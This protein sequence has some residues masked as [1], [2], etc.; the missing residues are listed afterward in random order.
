MYGFRIAHSLN[1]MSTFPR[2]R[3]DVIP[4]VQDLFLRLFLH[5]HGAGPRPPFPR[6]RTP[7][8]P[9]MEESFLQS[10]SHLQQ[11]SQV[12]PKM[13]ESFLQGDSNLQQRQAN[14]GIELSKINDVVSLERCKNNSALERLENRLKELGSEQDEKVLRCQKSLQ[15]Q[16]EYV[17]RLVLARGAGSGAV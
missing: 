1:E 10:D 4:T 9:K 14:L 3:T 16:M 13:E 11:R 15:Q 5:S 2:S 7:V 6:C 17:S 8:I 12:I